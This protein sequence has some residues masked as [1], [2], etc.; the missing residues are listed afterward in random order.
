[1]I[2]VRVCT[3]SLP[4][5]RGW[6]GRLEKS[7]DDQV[8][9]LD[10][11]AEAR[12]LLLHVL[13]QFRALDAF[14]PAGKVFDQGGDGELAAGLMAFEY[15]RLEVGA[16]GINGGRQTGAAGA[17]DDGVANVLSHRNKSL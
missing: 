11:R 8:A 13:D 16:G 3:V 7:T 17:Q 5:S 6:K 2:S 1:M 4:R 14:R 15:Q 10:L 9:H 12:G